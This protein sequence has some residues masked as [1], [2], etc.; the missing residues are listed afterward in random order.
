MGI[1][2]LFIFYTVHP[3]NIYNFPFFGCYAQSLVSQC[4][5]PYIS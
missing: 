3:K 2:S 4:L 5:K 1:W